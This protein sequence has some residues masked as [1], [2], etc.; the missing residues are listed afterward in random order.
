MPNWCAVNVNVEGPRE[1]LKQFEEAL[2]NNAI[3]HSSTDVSVCDT[4]VPMPEVESIDWGDWAHD[5]W[6]CKWADKMGLEYNLSA[7][8]DED[9]V[10][11]LVGNTPWTP[12]LEG[13]TKASS[14]YPR[15]VFGMTWDEPGMCFMGAA[16]IS[17]GK[18]LGMHEIH[19]EKYPTMDSEDFEDEDKYQDYMDTI[20]ERQDE[21]FAMALLKSLANR[22]DN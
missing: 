3:K 14:Y 20:S 4:F 19:S 12:P 9:D 16:I 7:E 15:L 13:Y 1:D 2:I 22:E 21:C 17:G 18:V 10:I 11:S 8:S 6:G 5:N